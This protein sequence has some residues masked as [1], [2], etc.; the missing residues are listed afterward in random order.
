MFG[1][2]F[3]KL[4]VL[5]AVIA[6]V[7]YGYRWWQRVQKVTRDEAEAL[8]RQRARASDGEDMVKCSSCD[9]YLSPRA[10]RSCGRAEC[11]YPG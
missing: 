8:A 7:W 5:A 11:P 1:F 9:T 10:A 2:S 4:L 6:A 3:A